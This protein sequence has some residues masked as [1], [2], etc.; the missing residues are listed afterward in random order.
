MCSGEVVECSEGR[1]LGKEK[2]EALGDIFPFDN[3]L[4]AEERL[5]LIFPFD[6]RLFWIL[7][8]HDESEPYF[9]ELVRKSGRIAE[10]F[11]KAFFVHFAPSGQFRALFSDP[12]IIRFNVAKTLLS[13]DNPGRGRKG[14]YIDGIEFDDI[15]NLQVHYQ[16]FLTGDI[17]ADKRRCSAIIDYTIVKEKGVCGGWCTLVDTDIITFAG[18][19]FRYL[20]LYFEEDEIDEWTIFEDRYI[21]YIAEGEEVRE[22]RRHRLPSFL[23]NSLDERLLN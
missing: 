1:E 3:S 14:I 13:L 9:E 15:D 20:T 7:K 11:P 12:F 2:N 19:K 23:S 5:G 4:F 22:E 8:G 18:G 6:I 10:R 21:Q 16:S 17:S